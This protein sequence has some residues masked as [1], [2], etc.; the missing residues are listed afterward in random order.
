MSLKSEPK[1]QREMTRTR[2][3]STL[4]QE[5]YEATVDRHLQNV[6]EVKREIDGC[7][8]DIKLIKPSS[9]PC[10]DAFRQLLNSCYSAYRKCSEDFLSYLRGMRT[11]E[12]LNEAAAHRL[13]MDTMRAKVDA[14]HH[15]LNEL[16][17]VKDS[18]TQW[19]RAGSTHSQHDLRKKISPSRSKSSTPSEFS[20]GQLK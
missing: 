17:N 20:A 7:I 8:D 6:P 4:G 14:V 12:S 16:C 10:K 5:Q 18:K 15:N 19:S 9:E 3:L 2:Q 13:I 1:S 11:P